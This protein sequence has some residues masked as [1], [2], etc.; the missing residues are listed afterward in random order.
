MVDEQFYGIA[1]KRFEVF[2]QH[3]DRI[4]HWFI[5][6]VCSSLDLHTFRNTHCCSINTEEPVLPETWKSCNAVLPW[7][8]VCIWFAG[9]F[10]LQLILLG[11]PEQITV[12]YRATQMPNVCEI[13]T[14][15]IVLRHRFVRM[16]ALLQCSMTS[17]WCRRRLRSF[18]GTQLWKL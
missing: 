2:P 3:L 12:P 10:V 6:I 15:A 1:S 4:I 16:R 13:K 8:L 5:E 11:W 17:L 9:E 18:E 14:E 7:E